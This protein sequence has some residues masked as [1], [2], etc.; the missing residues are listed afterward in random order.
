MRGM[1]RY[2]GEVRTHLCGMGCGILLMW[3]CCGVVWVERTLD[4]RCDGNGI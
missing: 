4:L 1:L 3:W 2:V